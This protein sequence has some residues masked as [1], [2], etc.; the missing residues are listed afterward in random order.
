MTSYKSMVNA[1]TDQ[2]RNL[3]LVLEKRN[4]EVE[5]YKKALRTLESENIDSATVGK[6]YHSV[7]VARWCEATSNRKY[8]TLL[9][10]TRQLRTDSFSL[11]S[12][13]M[14]Q[15]KQTHHVQ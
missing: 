7:M 2:A 3:N 1:C 12:R 15:E 13:L 8:D 5:N 10:E 4:F 6:L 9:T 11:E 14:E